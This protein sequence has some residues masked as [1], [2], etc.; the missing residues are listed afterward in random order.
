MFK[1]QKWVLT[2]AYWVLIRWLCQHLLRQ[3]LIQVTPPRSGVNTRC[4]NTVLTLKRKP[5]VLGAGKSQLQ[6]I[7]IDRARE[8]CAKVSKFSFLGNSYPFQEC[9][10]AVSPRLLGPARF[11]LVSQSGARCDTVGAPQKNEDCKHVD[12]G[13]SSTESL[14]TRYRCKTSCRPVQRGA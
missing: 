14:R 9:M 11:R 5:W 7:A 12:I 6:V 2:R 10:Q 4:V 8:T 1:R 3:V 13:H